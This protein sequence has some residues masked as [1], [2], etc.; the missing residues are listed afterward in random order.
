MEYQKSEKGGGTIREI[1]QDC[2]MVLEVEVKVWKS[3]GSDFRVIRA[4]EITL[5]DIGVMGSGF[6]VIGD[7]GY[8]SYTSLQQSVCC[9]AS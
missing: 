8:D 2:R 6:R 1:E 9:F 5:E 3:V 7:L 4:Q